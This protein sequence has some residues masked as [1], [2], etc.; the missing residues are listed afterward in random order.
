MQPSSPP[1]W[2]DSN[3]EV[4]R[5]PGASQKNLLLLKKVEELTLHAIAQEKRIQAMEAQLKEL[6]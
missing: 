1:A 3:Q 5:K 2:C 6:R 4:S